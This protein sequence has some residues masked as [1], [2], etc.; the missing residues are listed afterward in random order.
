[1]NDFG[2]DIKYALW[3]I[4]ALLISAPLFLWSPLTLLLVVAAVLAS[5]G[6]NG[7][8]KNRRVCRWKKVP[9]KLLKTEIGRYRVSIGQYNEPEDRYFPLAFYSYQ[10]DDYRGESNRYAFDRKSIWSTDREEVENIL[11]KLQAQKSLEVFVNPRQPREAV[12]NTTVSSTRKSHYRA[13]AISGIIIGCLW[14]LLLV[15]AN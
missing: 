5:V 15:K 14:G 1:M 8:L 2:W 13:L 11:T 7:E 3:L 4:A 12:L 6:I 10:Y 9:G